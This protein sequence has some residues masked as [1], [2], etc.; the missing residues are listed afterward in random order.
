VTAARGPELMVRRLPISR[1]FLSSE[2]LFP[3]SSLAP[4]LN[5]ESNAAFSHFSALPLRSEK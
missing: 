4:S 1:A 3:P 5:G 2:P